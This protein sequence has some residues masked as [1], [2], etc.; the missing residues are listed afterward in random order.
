MENSAMAGYDIPETHYAQSGDVSIAYQVYGEGPRDIVYVPGI[1]SNIEL[2]WEDEPHVEF[3]LALA[4]YFRV[5][6]F[7]KRGQGMSDPMDGPLSLE[8]RMDDL[9]AVMDA[10]KS[11]RAVVMGLSEGGPMS[12][13]FATTYPERVE[14]LVL[15]GTYPCSPYML[16][17]ANLPPIAKM[18]DQ[19]EKAWAT[20]AAILRFAPSMANDPDQVAK[21]MRFMRQTA[22]PRMIRRLVEANTRIDVRAILKDVQVPT[23]VIH[24]RDD[25][26]AT[27]D[28]GRYLADHIPD[29]V[30]LELPGQD[31]LPWIGDYTTMVNAIHH[32]TTNA[33]TTRQADQPIRKLATALFTDIENSTGLL[34]EMG[35]AAW[36]ETLDRHD[37][38]AR[39]VIER[40][41]GRFVKSTG[42]GCLAV[43]D[44]PTRAIRCAHALVGKLGEIGLTIRAGLH[45]GEIEPRSDDVTGLAVHIAARVMEQ[46][47]GGDVLVSRTVMDLT[48]GS[49]LT[50]DD[51]GIHTLKGVPGEFPLYR[52]L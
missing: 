21:A 47:D 5:I 25:Q 42:D 20:E 52:P 31:H 4:E 9:R 30:F 26:A 10:A 1:I 44:G 46:A 24:R 34:T 39:E 45:A 43:F 7:D 35:D 16:E 28:R 32:L 15:Y 14:H 19:V 17:P 6:A 48:A 38:L 27:A 18:L 8:E 12:V 49:D 11:E 13:L 37:G 33:S 41:E 36:R 29:A 23:L 51:A 40:H 22:S 3:M 2:A 50:F